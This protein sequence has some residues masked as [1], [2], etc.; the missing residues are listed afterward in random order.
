MPTHHYRLSYQYKPCAAKPQVEPLRKRLYT[1]YNGKN[2]P[3]AS[4]APQHTAKPP[5]TTIYRLNKNGAKNLSENLKKGVDKVILR[6]Y[7]IQAVRRESDHDS[8]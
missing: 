1:L 6:W 2:S 5:K 4:S 7:Y 3:P 8:R